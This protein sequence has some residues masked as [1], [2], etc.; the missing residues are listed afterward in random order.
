MYDYSWQNL[1]MYAAATPSYDDE[2][3]PENKYDE[4]LDACDPDNFKGKIFDGLT[5]K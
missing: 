5:V 3:S 1:V 2:E 4:Q